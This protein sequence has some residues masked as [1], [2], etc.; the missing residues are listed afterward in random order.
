MLSLS[1]KGVSPKGD[2]KV[3]FKEKLLNL[4]LGTVSWDLFLLKL[5]KGKATVKS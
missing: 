4:N 3:S 2:Q 5:R 1:G